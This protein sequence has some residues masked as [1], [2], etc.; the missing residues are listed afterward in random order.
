[1]AYYGALDC[2][3]NTFHLIIAKIGEE[4]PWEVVYR[5]RVF[6]Y[7]A[8]NGIET[9][10]PKSYKRALKTIGGFN[11][12]IKKYELAGF[13]AVGTAALR[14][15]DNGLQFIEEVKEKYGINIE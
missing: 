6:V 3:T 5:S 11:D 2:G 8:E 13:R 7:L 1:M 10:T 14:T 15:A 9:I 4:D 12:E